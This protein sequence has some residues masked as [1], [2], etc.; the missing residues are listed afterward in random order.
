MNSDQ[1]IPTLGTIRLLLLLCHSDFV[2]NA[3]FGQAKSKSKQPAVLTSKESVPDSESTQREVDIT[4]TTADT[5]NPET[6]KD[7]KYTSESEVSP[8]LVPIS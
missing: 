3:G 1:E 2:P 6:A 5:L 7:Y 4:P 8:G